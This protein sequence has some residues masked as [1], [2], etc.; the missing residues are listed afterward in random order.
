VREQPGAHVLEG[1]ET[2]RPAAPLLDGDAP[3]FL[4]H[5]STCPV[6]DQFKAKGGGR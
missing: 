6:A 2:C 3:M 1:A 4:N 5:W